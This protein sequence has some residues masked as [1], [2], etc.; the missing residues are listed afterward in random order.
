MRPIE[1]VVG[2][3]FLPPERSFCLT[4]RRE[5]AV[6]A[7]KQA[8]DGNGYILRIVDLVG[9]GGEVKVEF[10]ADLISAC[11]TDALEQGASSLRLQHAKGFT[12]TARPH[13][14]H[15]VRVVLSERN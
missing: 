14:I 2:E 3:Q 7:M 6:T 8:Y 4:D 12:L 5:I 15:T 13:G 10:A 1:P 9:K 11:E